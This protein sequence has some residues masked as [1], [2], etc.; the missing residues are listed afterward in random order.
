M[1]RDLNLKLLLGAAA[2]CLTAAGAQAQTMLSETDRQFIVD[3]AHGGHAEV[4][5]GESA[6]K[7]ENAA[8]SRVSDQPVSALMRT[9][10]TGNA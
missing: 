4:S 3:A 7:S 10:R 5:M 8:V 2:L 1:R 6:A 9:P